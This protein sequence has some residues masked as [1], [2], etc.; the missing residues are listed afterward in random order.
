M[1]REGIDRVKDRFYTKC[2]T[3]ND[4]NYQLAQNEDKMQIFESYCDFLNFFD[5][6]I[7]VQLSFLNQ[8]GNM[9]D[10]QASIDISDQ[11]D[12]FNSIRREYAGMLKNQLSKGNNGLVKTKHITFGIA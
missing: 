1:Y 4:V 9:Q 2:V 3:F 10:F 7:S 5:S 8:K 6:T 11:K 12:D